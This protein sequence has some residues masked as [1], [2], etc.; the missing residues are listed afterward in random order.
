M[1]DRLIPRYRLFLVLGFAVVAFSLFVLTAAEDALIVVWANKLF[2]GDM[3]T[4]FEA[5][6]TADKVISHT[7][8]VLLFV[9]LSL[10][11][12][13][14]GFAIATIVRSLRSTGR[15][16]VEAFNSAGVAGAGASELEEPWFGRYFTRFVFSGML[17]VLSMFV[18]T[19]W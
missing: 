15:S 13:G 8:K 14:I 6:Q 1:I 17:I 11:K 10:I 7:L 9:G 4:T 19:L 2:D 3:G 18:L 12:L 16:T 5:T